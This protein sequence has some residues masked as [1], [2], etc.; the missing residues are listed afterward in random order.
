VGFNLLGVNVTTT[1]PVYLVIVKKKERM[2][3]G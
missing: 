2:G 1:Q 3:K